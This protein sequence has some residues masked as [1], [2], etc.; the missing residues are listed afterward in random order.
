M[1]DFTYTEAA[2]LDWDKPWRSSLALILG[3]A[4]FTGAALLLPDG[5]QG[6]GDALA[7][8]ETEAPAAR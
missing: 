2:I 4:V 6:Q 3:I 8:T 7:M 5:A 1:R